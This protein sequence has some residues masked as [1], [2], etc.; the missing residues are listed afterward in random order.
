[1]R[2]SEKTMGREVLSQREEEGGKDERKERGRERKTET[3]REER[4]KKRERWWEGEK[5]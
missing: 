2:K 1:M 5:R 4:K 3:K